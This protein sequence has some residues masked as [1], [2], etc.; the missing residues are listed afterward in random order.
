M[1]VLGLSL[2]FCTLCSGFVQSNVASSSSRN[3]SL[4]LE[5]GKI[6][7]ARRQIFSQTLAIGTMTILPAVSDAGEFQVCNFGN[8]VL[9]AL[10]QSPH[11]S[12]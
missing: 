5:N 1:G 11:P 8:L 12:S 9:Q 2:V 10:L 4:R 3:T 7:E 6:D